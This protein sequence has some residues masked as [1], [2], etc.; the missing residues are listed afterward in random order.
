[1]LA[2]WKN[3]YDKPR[4]RIKK[5]RHHFAGKGLYSQSCGFSS[6][7]VRMWELIIKKAKHQRIDAF[8]LWRWK[9]L[10]RVSWVARRSNQSILKESKPE[11]SLEGLMLKLKLQYSR[12][13]M[14]R[15]N[16][17]EKIPVLGNIEGRR[18]R[19]DRGWDGWIASPTQWTWVW[20]NSRR[21]WRTG[22]AG[23]LQ[24]MGSQRVRHSWATEPQPV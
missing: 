1:M 7:H 16:S 20:A 22:R 24:A 8:K 23:L 17:L 13:L 3:S 15:A 10:L 9:R 19:D 4:Q 14:W 11:C 5:W 18:R 2:P 21:W 12:H 6:R